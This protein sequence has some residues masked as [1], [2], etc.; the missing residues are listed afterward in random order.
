MKPPVALPSLD[1]IATNPACAAELPPDAA[2]ALLS[3]CVVALA[4]LNGR[5]L[6]GT[7]ASNGTPP[8]ADRRLNVAEAAERLGM[9][10]DYLYR[11]ADTLPFT[12]RVG[13][14][15]G[16]SAAGIDKYLKQRTGR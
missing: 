1:A 16:F 10:R 15:L 6:A 4:A 13:R 5:L 8:E 14:S 9:S 2:H 3:R 11:H 12:I 7:A